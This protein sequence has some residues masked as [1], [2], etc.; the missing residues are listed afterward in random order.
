M[1]FARPRQG[2]TSQWNNHR[3]RGLKILRPPPLDEM[4][5]HKYFGYL[6]RFGLSVEHEEQMEG[7]ERV[8]V[9]IFLH[10]I[11]REEEREDGQELMGVYVASSWQPGINPS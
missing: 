2:R 8:L 3:L 1:R 6:L 10:N 9:Q 4:I 5:P 11:C 7:R